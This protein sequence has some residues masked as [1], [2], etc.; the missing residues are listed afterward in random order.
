MSEKSYDIA[1]VIVNW[2]NL[3][4]TRKAVNSVITS[5][6]VNPLV[7]VV[8]NGSSDD[9]VN[10][11]RNNFIDIQIISNESNMGFA[12]ASNQGLKLAGD[13][14]IPYVMFLN[15]DAYVE[16]DCLYKLL[17]TIK[18][19]V[20]IAGVAPFIYY[21]D[22]PE[23]IWYGGGIVRLWR[24]RIAHRYLR[25]TTAQAPTDIFRCDY[26]TGCAMLLKT[27]HTVELGGFDK[28]YGI[29]TE[30][31][32]LSMKLRREYGRLMVVPPA[33]AF[34]KVSVSS[35]GELSPFKAFHRGRS[36]ALFVRRWAK[37]WE[38]PTLIIGGILGGLIVSLRLLLG[39][40]GDVVAALWQGITAG[41][42]DS[43]VPDRYKLEFEDRIA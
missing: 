7:I 31:V 14:A 32:D 2:N 9:A 26:L 19:N 24:G 41:L 13:M 20:N 36:N 21:A 10:F 6:K 42:T 1:V 27:E 15:N 4:L 22:H 30:D 34:H 5:V 35:G 38:Y 3:E 25:K 17:K 29:Y 11:M 40:R 28:S 39:S 37:F 33:K 16:K 43:R 12:Y 23:T 8:D 18:S